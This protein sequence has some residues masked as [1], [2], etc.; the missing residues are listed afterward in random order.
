MEEPAQ[1]IK[2]DPCPQRPQ[3]S[4]DPVGGHETLVHVGVEAPGQPLVQGNL[5][6]KRGAPDQDEE[7]EADGGDGPESAR[8]QR[9]RDRGSQLYDHRGND[10]KGDQPGM[11]GCVV[12]EA[13]LTDAREEWVVDDLNNPNDAGHEQGCRRVGQ[14]HPLHA[15]VVNAA[16]GLRNANLRRRRMM[17]RFAEQRVPS[18]HPQFQAW[19]GWDG[20]RFGSRRV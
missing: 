6:E 18:S 9:K 8:A 2:D 13:G 14:E 11:L 7:A 5:Q 1:R 10:H 15:V 17:R 12:G 20:K 19:R 3:R 4:S 16:P